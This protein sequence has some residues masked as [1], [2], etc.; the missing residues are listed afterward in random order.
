MGYAQSGV[1]VETDGERK[2]GTHDVVESNVLS[3][4][5]VL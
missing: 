1:K 3:S 5:S 4:L 2:G